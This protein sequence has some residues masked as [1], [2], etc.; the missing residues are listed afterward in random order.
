MTVVLDTSDIDVANQAF[1]DMYSRMR[2]TVSG[3]QHHARIVRDVVGDAELHRSA[4]TMRFDA[5]VEPLGAF[6]FARV[7]NGTVRYE[8]SLRSSAYAASD[9][10]LMARP[11]EPYRAIMD[12]LDVE[13]ALLPLDRIARTVGARAGRGNRPVSFIGYRP[14]SEAAVYTWNRCFN[15]VRQTAAAAAGNDLVADRISGLLAATAL[16]T[17]PN[18]AQT[19]TV[20][21]RR[22]A[23]PVTVRRAVTFIDENAHRTISIADIAAAAG[24]TGRAVQLAF[25]RHL[26]TTPMRYLRR[27]RLNRA[28]HDLR[29]AAATDPTT[30]TRV[31]ARWGFPDYRSFIAAHRQS[32]GVSPPDIRDTADR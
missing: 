22:D 32:Y 17:F 28:H 15:F 12:R 23:H 26:D 1:N 27:V 20:E 11:E 13:F 31:A 5:D 9:V 16:A 21:D 6:F 18:T 8:S 29:A 4:F 24:V 25:R 7:R 30:I 10:F 14:T 3:N 2:L 19:D